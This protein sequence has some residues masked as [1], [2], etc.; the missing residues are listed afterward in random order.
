MKPIFLLVLL[1]TSVIAPS[2]S[3]DDPKC[4]QDD[5]WQ[6]VV[7]NAYRVADKYATNHNPKSTFVSIKN[8]YKFVKQYAGEHKDKYLLILT[9]KQGGNT[10][11][12]VLLPLFDTNK[13]STGLNDE[14]PLWKVVNAKYNGRPY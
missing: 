14:K 5:M 8:N 6:Y 10:S 2:Y 13:P 1:F 12:A 11:F 9:N 4:T 3:A 7:N